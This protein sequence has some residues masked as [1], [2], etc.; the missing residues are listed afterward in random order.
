MWVNLLKRCL[1]HITK[2]NKSNK[3]F[4]IKKIKPIYGTIKKFVTIQVIFLIMFHYCNV[5][6]CFTFEFMIFIL[7]ND[8]VSF[9]LL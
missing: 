1:R 8:L 3:L 5:S 4:C 9:S 2:T 7:N 6:K